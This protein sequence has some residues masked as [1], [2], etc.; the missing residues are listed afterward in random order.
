[1]IY[2]DINWITT[3]HK[4]IEKVLQPQ[5]TILCRC[6]RY[7]VYLLRSRQLW[8]FV[9]LAKIGFYFNYKRCRKLMQTLRCL[10]GDHWSLLP[11]NALNWS[12]YLQDY[13]N[14]QTTAII[15]WFER[16]SSYNWNRYFG[17]LLSEH[18]FMLF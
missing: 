16:I 15:L 5:S 3:A 13:G 10:T 8:H 7:F 12:F 17:I 1:M 2:S 14:T 18:C 9:L 11:Y 6:F 4:Y